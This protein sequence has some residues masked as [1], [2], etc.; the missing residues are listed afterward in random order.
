MFAAKRP[1]QRRSNSSKFFSVQRSN[2]RSNVSF[3]ENTPSGG[4]HGQYI[5]GLPEKRIIRGGSLGSS[6]AN[7]SH[8]RLLYRWDGQD[9][10]VQFQA[11]LNYAALITQTTNCD[12]A[13]SG[14]RSPTSSTFTLCTPKEHSFPPSPSRE[15]RC[16][17]PFRPQTLGSSVFSCNLTGEPVGLVTSSSTPPS[18]SKKKCFSNALGYTLVV[19]EVL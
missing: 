2:L 4:S 3:E 13:R 14:E 9:E 5:I 15:T 17:V 18:R 8:L 19:L 12:S 10:L 6:A 1:P 16:G 7:P 11:V